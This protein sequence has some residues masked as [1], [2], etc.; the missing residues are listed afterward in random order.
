VHLGNGCSITAVEQGKSVDTS[1]GLT[2]LEGLVMGTRSG[3]IDPAVHAYLARN[4][5]MDIDAIDTM[6]NKESGL[7]GLCGMNDMRDIHAAIEKGDEKAKIALDVQTYRNKKY[8]G[9]YMAVLGKV[10]A[11]VFTAGIGENDE[12]V[13]LESL[14]G[15]EA[16]GVKID[17]KSND[18]RAKGPLKIS[19]DD[20]SVAVWV[21]P[22]NEELAIARET[23]DVL[24]K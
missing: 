4:K 23:R 8:I 21:I 9:S 3:D 17:E 5:G 16:F 13:R 2:P 7:K 12:I 14:R 19:T 10:D 20:S 1:M 24:T 11:I 15:L 18:Q 6:L 22:T